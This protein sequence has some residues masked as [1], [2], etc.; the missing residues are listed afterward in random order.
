MKFNPSSPNFVRGVNMVASQSVFFFVLLLNKRQR[1]NFR[2]SWLSSW[3]WRNCIDVVWPCEPSHVTTR[4]TTRSIS[5]PY[6]KIP[7][8][9]GRRSFVVKKR[10]KLKFAGKKLSRKSRNG[11]GHCGGRCR[12][13]KEAVK[14]NTIVWKSTIMFGNLV[15]DDDQSFAC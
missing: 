8:R 5:D 13:E 6:L 11:K 15:K 9:N 2:V 3:M 14:L 12:W 4:L 10:N 7:A 1:D